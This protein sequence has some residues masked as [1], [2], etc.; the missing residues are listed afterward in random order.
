MLSYLENMTSLP[1]TKK[2]TWSLSSSGQT[3]AVVRGFYVPMIKTGFLIPAGWDSA[4]SGDS[5]LS[6]ATP[7]IDWVRSLGAT[8]TEVVVPEPP[9]A[10]ES[11]MLSLDLP[12]MT[13][14]MLMIRPSSL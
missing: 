2:K 10:W 3:S 11:A 5:L 13:S 8:R 7:A 6:L 4:I 9:G 12:K 14:M 1:N